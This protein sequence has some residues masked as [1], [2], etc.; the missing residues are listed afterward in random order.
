MSR[1]R[2]LSQPRDQASS[3]LSATSAKVYIRLVLT[4]SSSKNFIAFVTGGIRARN[5]HHGNFRGSVMIGRQ[6][7]WLKFS[8]Y[9]MVGSRSSDRTIERFNKSV[10]FDWTTSQKILLDY[11]T[12]LT[13]LQ[14]M[15]FLY[16]TAMWRLTGLG[17]L[18]GCPCFRSRLSWHSKSCSQLRTTSSF[19]SVPTV[20]I[21]TTLEVA[22]A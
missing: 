6:L 9:S 11:V 14:Q 3:A 20:S 2:C 10:D 5:V 22:S 18:F 13:R 1:T 7:E 17:G 21:A 19:L 15:Q 16:I 4:N 12:S 8:G